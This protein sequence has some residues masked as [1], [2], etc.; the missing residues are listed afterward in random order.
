MLIVEAAVALT[1]VYLTLLLW[2]G[3]HPRQSQD[4]RKLVELFERIRKVM[5]VVI[6]P[7]FKLHAKASFAIPDSLL[8]HEAFLFTYIVDQ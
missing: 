8:L 5:K 7:L 1:A 3:T 4:D 2:S 6:H